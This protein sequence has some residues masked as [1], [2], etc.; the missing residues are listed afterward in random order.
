[1]RDRLELASPGSES[2]Y[3]HCVHFVSE[4]LV[5]MQRSERR[6]AICFLGATWVVGAVREGQRLDEDVISTLAQVY[7]NETQGYWASAD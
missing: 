3:R 2:L 5:E 1:M 4:H 7:E 6:S